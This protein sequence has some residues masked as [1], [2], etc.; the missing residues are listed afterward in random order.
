MQAA[1]IPS[2]LSVL[3]AIPDPQAHCVDGNPL[4]VIGVVPLL[5]GAD[6]A[7]LCAGVYLTQAF[8]AGSVYDALGM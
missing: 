6:A 8:Q 2:Q 7:S 1:M 4:I 5:S 3:R